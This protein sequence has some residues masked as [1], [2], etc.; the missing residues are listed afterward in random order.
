MDLNILREKADYQ[1]LNKQQIPDLLKLMYKLIK[2]N[3]TYIIAA[4][5]LNSKMPIIAMR[6][7]RKINY[8]LCPRI[9]KISDTSDIKMETDYSFR[10]MYANIERL[11]RIEIMYMQFGESN[12]LE[13][14]IKTC[15][16]HNL[17]GVEPLMIEGIEARLFQKG[18][19]YLDGIIFLDRAITDDIPDLTG[20]PIYRI[21]QS[22]GELDYFIPPDNITFF[23]QVKVNENQIEKC[24]IG[25]YTNEI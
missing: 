21:F 16:T 9:I 4:N 22:N 5:Q 20:K 10:R 18:C 11:N 19:D 1:L 13:E 3:T 2:D 7:K 12:N 17:K 15:D 24:Q 14:F 8:Y 25:V 6:D 23:N